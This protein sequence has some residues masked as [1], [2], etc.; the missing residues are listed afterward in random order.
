[1]L[2]TGRAGFIGLHL[3]ERLVMAGDDVVDGSA[4]GHNFA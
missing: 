1:M 3:R 2:V 4:H